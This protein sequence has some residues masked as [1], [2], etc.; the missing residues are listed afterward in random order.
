[1]KKRIHVLFAPIVVF[2]L[3]LC[4]CGRLSAD[5]YYDQLRAG[6]N[7][8][9]ATLKE[10]DTVRTDVQSS[11]D[12]MLEQT[13][14]TQICERAE[15]ALDKFKEMNPPKEYSEKH[16]ALVESA[17]H[18]KEFVRATKKVLT[19]RTP[20]E[21]SEYTS[22]VQAVLSGV[23]EEKQFASVF[24]DIVLELKNELGK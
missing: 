16:E 22:E 23:P 7:E 2:V 21:L 14:A 20:A 12:I 17:E 13:K 18:E 1:M 4:G 9:S 8:Y 10:F 11:Q 19:A 6:L 15:K 3:L 24:K 5:E